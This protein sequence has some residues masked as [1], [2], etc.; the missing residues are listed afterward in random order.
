VTE[1]DNTRYAP[2]S[3]MY[4]HASRLHGPAHAARVFLL[5]NMIAERRGDCDLE[6]V[7]WAAAYHDVRRRDDGVDPEHG[8]RSA[9]L[10]LLQARAQLEPMRQGLAAYAMT[11]HAPADDQVP[12]WTPELRVLKDADALDRVRLGDFDPS[13]LRTPEAHALIGCA[14]E[15]YEQAPHAETWQQ[16]QSLARR[17][18]TC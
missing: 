2:D 11:W 10:F 16:V 13:Y 1:L 9:G 14:R 8:A 17:L 7:R 3:R 18:A 6:V 4:L 15:L 5:A 12:Y